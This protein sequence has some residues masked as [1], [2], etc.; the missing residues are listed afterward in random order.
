MTDSGQAKPHE[1]KRRW[2]R[3]M[4]DSAVK[5]KVSGADGLSTYCY[6][7][8]NDVGE[9]GMCLYLAHE[10]KIGRVIDLTLTLPYSERAIQCKVAVRN[11]ESFKYGV[12][13]KEMS[14]ID[15][16]ILLETC[17]RLGVVQEI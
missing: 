9:G 5:V 4:I 11:R 7:R 12:E 15:R 6:G 8:A 17:R 2:K 3:Y 14:P 1:E 10:L 16:E 13:F